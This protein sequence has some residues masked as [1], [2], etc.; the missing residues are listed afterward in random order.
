MISSDHFDQLKQPT[1][2]LQSMAES[3]AEGNVSQEKNGFNHQLKKF[4]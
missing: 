2:W 3:T 1:G 4:L